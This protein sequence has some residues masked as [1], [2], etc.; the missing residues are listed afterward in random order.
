MKKN[1]SI[2][3]IVS[4]DKVILICYL[5]L[6]LIGILMMLDIT[7]MQSMSMFYHHLIYFIFSIA[8][9]GIIFYFLDLEKLR[10]L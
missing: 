6:C 2:Q 8:V 10:P 3:Y 4:Y 5:S 1:K 7:S 9:L